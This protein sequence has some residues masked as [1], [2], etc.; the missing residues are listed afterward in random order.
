MN[1]DITARGEFSVISTFDLN[2]EATNGSV[3]LFPGGG[4]YNTGTEVELT[5]TPASEEY[6]FSDWTGGITDSV[7]P[8]TV[9]MD[10]NY[11]ITANFGAYPTYTLNITA[12]N[13]Y[14]KKTPDQAEY[15]EG[16]EVNIIAIADDDYKFVNWTGDASVSDSVYRQDITMD[17]DFTLTAHFESTNGITGMNDLNARL[18]DVNIFPNPN[19]GSEV[20]IVLNGNINNVKVCI[21]N[22]TGMK[23]YSGTF[24]SNTFTI[25]VLEIE[26]M[27]TGYY[28]MEIISNDQKERKSLIVR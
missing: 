25:P 17:H 12:N 13:G 9:T 6:Y 11:T 21:Y 2:I 4:T 23:L 8:V 18:S 5:A 24:N 26:E 19:D 22:V 15:L 10:D 28:L 16:T 1:S 3:Q 20:N 27:N 7:N 14:V